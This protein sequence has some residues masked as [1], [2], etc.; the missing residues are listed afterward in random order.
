MVYIPLRDFLKGSY[1][2]GDFECS[3]KDICISF[4]LKTFAMTHV[5]QTLSV[6]SMIDKLSVAF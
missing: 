6:P 5:G 2:N 1:S 3:D 4:N